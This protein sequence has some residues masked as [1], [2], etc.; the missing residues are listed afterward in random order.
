MFNCS[1][2]SIYYFII[3]NIQNINFYENHMNFYYDLLI[4]FKFYY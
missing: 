3:T 4:D 1:L 2:I